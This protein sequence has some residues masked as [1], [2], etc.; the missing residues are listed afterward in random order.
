M[1]VTNLY[2]YRGEIR[3][4]AS[5]GGILAIVT[6][7]EEGHA[8]ALYQ[9]NVEKRRMTSAELP[10][11]G[12]ALVISD[13]AKPKVYVAG[14]D[15]RIYV[16]AWESGGFAPLG[17]A[18]PAPAAALALVS[19]G[20]LAA[21]CGDQLL[22]LKI[23]GRTPGAVVQQFTLP[24]PGTA[25]A[26]DPSGVWLAV[27]CAR[28]SLA[29]FDG[30]DKAEFVAAEHGQI[31]QGAV[32]SLLFDRGELRVLSGGTDA[33]IF[34][35]HVRGKL[36]PE[37]RS[38]RSGHD[39]AVMGLVHGPGD[40]T[41]SGGR[42]K[43]VKVWTKGQGR[44]STLK[45]LRSVCDLV[46]LEYKG[47]PHLAIAGE[48][49]SVQLYTI[50]ASGKPGELAITVEGAADWVKNERRESDP[51]AREK[52]LKRIAAWN[53][54]IAID[55]LGWTA[56]NDKDHALR[57]Y[58]TE[59]LG[60]SGNPR[61]QKPLAKLLRASEEAVRLEA[62]AGLR[63]LEGASSLRPLRLALESRHPDIGVVAI[64]ALTG[65]A[66]DDDI[67][68]DRLI[69]AL[70]DDPSEVRV[71]AL[72]ALETLSD[73]ASPQASL[74]GL[75]SSKADLRRLALIRCWQRSLVSRP[76]VLAA[77]RLHAADSDANV[78]KT[79]FQ[80]SLLARPKL[81]AALRCRD[82]QLHRQL[83][84][85]ESA[86]LPSLDLGTGKESSIK[87]WA[88]KAVVTVLAA[89][90]GTAEEGDG[91]AKKPPKAKKVA[92]SSVSEDDRRPL[93]EAMASRALDTSL[94]G[95][96]G[97]A[98]LG[99]PRALGTLLQLSRERDAGV[100]V[101]VCKSLQALGDPRGSA[102][103][104]LLLRDGEASVRDAA[105][106]ALVKLESGTP[107]AIAEAGLLAEHEDVRRRGLD[108]LV[109]RLRAAHKAGKL[110]DAAAV[111]LLER[112]LGDAG[113][114]VR[115]EAFKAVLNLDVD[116][117][118][119]SSLRFALRS[120]HADIRREVL[121][122]VLGQIE[123]SWAWELLL[124]LFSDPDSGVRSEAFEFAMK[125]TR[126][127]GE[128]PLRAA[129][130]G[131]YPDLRL[132]ATEILS[133]RK[134]PGVQELLATATRDDDEQVRRM[135]IDALLV[136]EADEALVAAMSS[137][138]ADVVVR[139]AA[140]RAV[141]GDPR[142]L[143]ALLKVVG[144][145]EPEVPA[146]KT[147]WRNRVVAGLGG[148]E[149]L[150]DPG[151]RA[152][153]SP[154]L[155]SKDAAIRRA[156]IR[157]LAAGTRPGD[158]AG[159]AGLQAALAHDDIAVRM[160]AAFGLALC[161][162]L[163]GAS[164]LFSAKDLGDDALLAA[165]ALGERA[166]DIFM[167]FLD[168]RNAGL[169]TRSMLLLL[170]QELA[171]GDGVPDRS[172][173][174]LSAANP[175]V[176]LAAAEALENFADPE[177][178][179]SFLVRQINDR[180]EGKAAWT[181]S[182]QT[183]ATLAEV[184]TFGD[185]TGN[186]QF[187]ARAAQLLD[188]L[189]QEKQEAFDRQWRIFSARFA[190]TLS[191]TRARAKEREQAPSVY[192]P[193]ELRALVFGAYAG[194]SRLSGGSAEARIRQTSIARLVAVARGGWA[195]NGAVFSVLV[196]ALGDGQAT[197]RTL[198]FDSL[199]DLGMPAE[200]LATEA[201]GAG[202]HDVGGLGLD[203]LARSDG[204][205]GSAVLEEVIRENTDGLEIEAAR[206]LAAFRSGVK[207]EGTAS[208][209][210]KEKLAAAWIPVHRFAL[211]A[212]SERLRNESLSGLS[213]SY[214]ADGVGPAAD[215]LRLALG[216]KYRELRSAAAQALAERKDSASFDVLV[217]IL[218]GESRSDQQTAIRSLH[219]LADP[220]AADVFLDR[221][222]DDA[223]AT[224][225]VDDLLRAAGAMR[226][227]KV[228]DRLLGYLESG[229]RRDAAYSA[230]LTTSGHDQKI[231]DPEDEGKEG[232]PGWEARQHPRSDAILVRLMN[233]LRLLGDDRNLGRL[234][235]AATWARGSKLDGALAPL[236]SHAKPE[237]RNGAITALSWRLRKRDADPAPLI[238]AL[239]GGDP[240]SLFLAA[241]GLA[242]AGRPEGISTLLAGVDL[243]PELSMRKRA[244]LALGHLADV[245]A[246]DLLLRLAGEEGHALQEQ[247]A[248]ALGHLREA[249]PD[250]ADK[251][252][253][254]LK[255][256]SGAH[257]VG[258]ARQAL[259]GLRFFGGRDAWALIRGAASSEEWRLR[260]RAADLLRFDDA[261]ETRELL[262]TLLRSERNRR[263][264]LAAGRSIRQIYGEES[265][266]ADYAF[267]EGQRPL[268]LQ[269]DLI[270]R[271]RERGDP[272]RIL[273][274]L[275]RVQ[276]AALRP[277][278]IAILTAR[279]P[280]PIAAATESLK[281]STRGL[282][283]AVAARILGT[284]GDSLAEEESAALVEAGERWS[285]AW[286]EE[287]ARVAGT[288]VL[289]A[290]SGDDD[291]DDDD[292][293]DYDDYD[294]DDDDYD[295]DDDDDDDYDDDDDDDEPSHI[296]NF[297]V[298]TG[299][300]AELREPYLWLLWACGRI[301]VGDGLLIAAATAGGD[302]SRGQAI[303]RAGVIGL[304]G[305]AGALS[306][307]AKSSLNALACGG[308]A[309]LRALAAA[310]LAGRDQEAAAA[311]V[312]DLLDDGV[313]VA[314]LLDGGVGDAAKASLGEAA[315]DT[316]RQGVA[317]PYLV[318]L[319]DVEGLAS[320][321]Q[322]R[323][324]SDG[325]RLGLLEALARIADEGALEVLRTFG[326]DEDEDEELRKAAWRAVRR[327][328]RRAKSVAKAPRRSRWEVQP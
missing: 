73:T 253:A 228:A 109:K 26:C 214:E 108:L 59:L 140:A 294:D 309:E 233:A 266:E 264:V 56:E 79:A 304:A 249:A 46:M 237:L 133:K 229:E 284:A 239:G 105:F 197:V 138:H 47:K 200:E 58:A 68:L 12:R 243:M 22:L 287:L 120:L 241:E 27:G 296:A 242:L 219:R 74:L 188:A 172:L 125:R 328:Q 248:E 34:T 175:R 99:D 52:S 267:L 1:S 118:G 98:L 283:V 213:G 70:G 90:A 158:A 193:E 57:A 288:I 149:E 313:S 179:F 210:D 119:A 83:H 261:P 116:G 318:A 302:D 191:A 30:E 246:L 147:P 165:L 196:P 166:H 278:L 45:G 160:G 178:F 262:A 61:A 86:A 202:Q 154:L 132:A 75:R 208:D 7:H 273:E 305:G 145:E 104:R 271:L 121:G 14:E 259:T 218:G 240:H 77:L 136:N 114:S 275:P 184:V 280:L 163:S 139:A 66:K 322:D 44:S 9:V 102:R 49:A 183:V 32:T 256:L 144:E 320:R 308:D 95:T 124:E 72:L 289:S 129:L 171:E 156:A 25:I 15:G 199:R 60:A 281:S 4:V 148:L 326:R 303:R 225:R 291:D 64:K 112:A 21:I 177:A 81:A 186:P 88:R 130:S 16:R 97:L 254:V 282:T 42:D 217:E 13:E 316:H 299:K 250:R 290:P 255:R 236:I 324:L 91:K 317:L 31:H 134:A 321:L 272:L 176:R 67:A 123:Q 224:A 150:G 8:T 89:L 65:L 135:A 307:E 206:L 50:D 107:L 226:V 137:P 297:G 96:R 204:A 251:V 207:A 279:T 6:T 189:A 94:S 238:Q 211:A 161:G 234:F 285:K 247:A 84:E 115:S 180:G 103:L 201:I 235:P 19:D 260:E 76:E 33:K 106:S 232:S 36:E 209:E 192:A 300:L 153:V 41:Y 146:L 38:G 78:R 231:E 128:E 82:A 122:E 51:K 3:G 127:I 55:H 325:L 85:L 195:S 100:R 270:E 181:I 24:E 159:I 323:G 117:G 295:D 174:A 221:V 11:G 277:P 142:A 190:A 157:A 245:R 205:G 48:D 155:E 220:R 35:T 168:H 258:V 43:V 17:D 101:A 37:L 131:P 194:L 110:A 198:A 173:A 203:L 170:L 301:G 93:L 69:E 310:A 18:L 53:D 28:G 252:F 215:G 319:G 167:S 62:L 286:S 223:S 63:G 182:A 141:H 2:T 164:V 143:S 80:I 151:A 126:G 315:V 298:D 20:R 311:L 216:S 276:N 312:G 10:C 39:D 29:I 292:D 314:R 87:K 23:S 269:P 113:K 185:E 152:S 5:R 265:V 263:V 92:E 244:V 306:E 274:V 162:E 293:D 227:P 222:D 54:A 169:R 230:I 111:A 71:A 187:K 268:E 40:R 257:M 212:R 327:G